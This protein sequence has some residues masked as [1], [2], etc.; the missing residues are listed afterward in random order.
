MMILAMRFRRAW[1]DLLTKLNAVATF[2][3]TYLS[4]NGQ[5]PAPAEAAMSRLPEPWQFIARL[6]VPIAWG[7]LVEYAKARAIKKSAVTP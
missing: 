1:A 5:L 4:L 7:T 2:A 3:L 6:F